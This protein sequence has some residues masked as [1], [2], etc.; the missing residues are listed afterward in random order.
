M[1][2]K[3]AEETEKLLQQLENKFGSSKSKTI[4][5]KK[6]LELCVGNIISSIL[7]GHTY[8]PND[9]T[10]VQLKQ[11]IEEITQIFSSAKI[12]MLNNCFLL[13]FVPLFGHFG[14]DEMSKQND[15]FL[16]ILINELKAHKE[17]M[18][19]STATEPDDFATAYLMGK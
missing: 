3:I 18:N 15:I 13:R 6:D 1:E 19:E 2:K 12:Q 9:P 17:K 5:V 16:D 10:F 4:S 14:F 7:V 8:E 11:S